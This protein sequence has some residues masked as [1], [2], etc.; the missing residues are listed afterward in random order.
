MRYLSLTALSLMFALSACVYEPEQFVES[1]KGENSNSNNSVTD[2]GTLYAVNDGK[3][4]CNPSVSQDPKNYPASMLWLNFGG[5]LK[6]KASDSVYTTSKVVQHD[7]LSVS[8]TSG[9]VL[10]YLMRDTEAGD[11][12][13]QD[14]EWSTHPNYIV[15]LRAFNSKGE[16]GCK[17]SDM[18]YGM[19]AVRMSDKKKFFF[20]NKEMSEFATPH[21]WV[22]TGAEPD[23]AAAES[24]VEGFF[25]TNQVRLVYVN[26]KDEIVFVDY[27]NGGTKGA[28]T[29]KKPSGVDG[30]MMDSPM[31]SPDGNYVVYNM[32]NSSMTGWK[33]FIQ[34]LSGNSK[35]IEI[36]KS[37]GMISEPV[38]PRW[39]TYAERLF[40][41]WTEFPQ[42]SQFVNK[43]DLSEVSV[44][45][46]S[47]GRTVMREV[48]VATG[49]PADL[50]FAWAG[51]MIEIAPI[52]MIGGRSPDGRFVATGTNLGF[53]LELP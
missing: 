12:Q 45:D 39:F 24:T 32:I 44:Q 11:C 1:E 15:A 3:Q 2:M 16:S 37:P 6:V 47:A 17:E 42:G 26:K 36:E 20:Y 34:E 35:P 14:P 43:N 30:W 33:S 51:D 38:Q 53:L 40:V 41:M 27:A 31:I 7:R 8:D 52:P 49:A 46:G 25:G 23:T 19:F 29:L 22:E 18:D 50:A 13:F 21:L 5:T 28:K 9:K 4:I 10:W 48:S